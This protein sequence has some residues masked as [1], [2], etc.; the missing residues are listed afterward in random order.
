MRLFDIAH[1]NF[2][3]DY[4]FFLINTK[5]FAL[6]NKSAQHE[7]SSCRSGAPA[8]DER[9]CYYT[10]SRP[11]QPNPTPLLTLVPAT[12]VYRLVS[13][14]IFFAFATQSTGKLAS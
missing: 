12:L 10:S 8:H 3:D 1:L 6:A 14:R 4:S 9:Q 13:K 5:L 2:T 11:T 7:S